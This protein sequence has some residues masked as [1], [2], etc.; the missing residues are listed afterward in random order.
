MDLG[1]QSD[2]YE[3][4]LEIFHLSSKC[5]ET[6]HLG[7]MGGRSKRSLPPLSAPFTRPI[8]GQMCGQ[9]F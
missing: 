2:L 6:V 3:P 7:E 5:G 1:L 9:D 8:N 4:G